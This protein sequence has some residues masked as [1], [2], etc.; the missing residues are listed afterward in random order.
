MRP[1]RRNRNDPLPPFRSKEQQKSTDIIDLDGVAS[2][3]KVQRVF[4]KMSRKQKRLLDRLFESIDMLSDE[5]RHP[6]LEQL[7]DYTC[8]PSIPKLKHKEK[9]VMTTD[10]ILTGPK[11]K[12]IHKFLQCIEKA[13]KVLIICDNQLGKKMIRHLIEEKR[14]IDIHKGSIVFSFVFYT[15]LVYN[16]EESYHSRTL[17]YQLSIMKLPKI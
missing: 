17:Y 8:H 10:M 13:A 6:Y 12:F 16:N 15:T 4:V 11:F 1:K 3:E 7:L 9:T 5:E 2:D 14:Y